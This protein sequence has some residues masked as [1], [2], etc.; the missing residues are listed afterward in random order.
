MFSS[1]SPIFLQIIPSAFKFFY[2][3][4]YFYDIRGPHCGH[5]IA[6]IGNRII[7]SILHISSKNL[8]SPKTINNS[9]AGWIQPFLWQQHL[10]ACPCDVLALPPNK[11]FQTEMVWHAEW[12]L[13]LS[14]MILLMSVNIQH[15]PVS[16]DTAYI[17]KAVEVIEFPKCT[18][19][20]CYIIW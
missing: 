14:H 2:R 16:H 8:I 19:I 7:H 9:V 4:C 1:K 17:L 5:L 13:L 10:Y 20:M 3:Y 11:L 18:V 12:M 15:C 6:F